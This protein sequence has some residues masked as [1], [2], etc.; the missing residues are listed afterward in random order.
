MAAVE[1]DGEGLA[2]GFAGQ[3]GGGD[4]ELQRAD[5][6]VGGGAGEGAGLGVEGEPSGRRIT[7]FQCGGVAQHIA[8]I[9]VAEAVGRQREAEGA[10]FQ[11]T[12]IGQGR[13]DF[14]GVV[15]V[16]HGDVEGRAGDRSEMI[17]A[18]HHKLEATHVAVRGFP[19]Q[20]S[21]DGVVA[22]PTR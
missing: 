6:G 8:H 11:G 4:A 10:V 7:V 21:G 18:F 2:G 1:P 5:I 13:A 20:Y 22:E 15:G 16:L 12:Q 19:A 17:A 9:H 14:G 3:I